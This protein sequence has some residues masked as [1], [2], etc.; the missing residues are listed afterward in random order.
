[1][2][3]KKIV[4][5]LLSL[6]M[7]ASMGMINIYA[8]ETATTGYTDIQ[9]HWAKKSIENLTSLGISNASLTS[10]N[11]FQPEK[12]ITRSETIEL[13]LKANLPNDLLKTALDSVQNSNSFTDT[14]NHKLRNYIELSK[15]FEIVVGYGDGTFKPDG[16]I[17]REEF[18]TIL[19]KSQEVI[20]K[21]AAGNLGSATFSDI[22]KDRWSYENISAA[23]KSGIVAGYPNGTFGPQNDITRAEAY[24]MVNNY[25]NLC[26]ANYKG[27]VGFASSNGKPLEG[28]EVNLKNIKSDKIV[29]TVLSNKYGQYRFDVADKDNFK[30]ETSDGDLFGMIPKVTTP[31]SPSLLASRLTLEKTV[32]IS[33]KAYNSNDLGL[34]EVELLFK[35]DKHEFRTV[36]NSSGE[37]KLKLFSYNTYKVYDSSMGQLGEIYLGNSELTNLTLKPTVFATSSNSSEYTGRN[38]SNYN[39]NNIQTGYTLTIQA[40]TGGRILTGLSGN[41]NPGVNIDLLASPES[42]Y[43]FDKWISSNGGSFA[44]I[45]SASTKFTMPANDTTIVANFT[46]ID[47]GGGE[48]NLPTITVRT[49][50]PDNTR[51]NGIDITYTATASR[52]ASITEISYSINGGAEEYIYLSGGN[53]IT[54]KGTLG[55]GRVL[56]IPGE[57]NIKFFVK[58]SAG[59]TATFDVRNKPKYDF[60]SMPEYDENYMDDL[61]DGSGLRYATNRIVAFAK[62][63]ATVSQIESAISSIGGTIAG[64]VNLLGMYSIQIPVNT[65]SALKG[66]CESLQSSYPELFDEVFLDIVEDVGIEATTQTNDAWWNNDQWG[67]TAINVPD[68]WSNY[69]GHIRNIK[70]GVVDNGFRSTH[71]DLNIPASNVFNRSLGDD[72]HGTHVIGTIGAIHNNNKG[73]AGVI[74]IRRESLY[75]FDSFDSTDRN[76]NI[77]GASSLTAQLEGLA[78]NIAHGTKIVNYSMG[79]GEQASESNPEY[80]MAMEKL[81]N[82]GYD[83]VVVHSAGN[84]TRDASLNGCFSHVTEADLRDHIITVGSTDRNGN[85]ASSSNY[86]NMVD[87]VAPGVGIYS[88]VSTNDSAYDN[89]NGTSMAAPHVTGV[90]A[91]VW[92]ANPGLSG[93]QVKQIIVDSANNYGLEVRDNRTSVPANNRLTYHQVTAKAAV[94]MAIGVTPVLTTGELAGQIIAAMPDG[95][96]GNA[97]VGATISLYSGINNE[98]IRKVNSIA[99]GQYRIDRIDTGRYYLEIAAEGYI[100]ERFFVQIEAGVTTYIH[101]LSAVPESSENGT[102]SGSIINAFNGSI[103]QDEIKLEFRRG[104]DYDQS[105]PGNVVKSIVVS[106]GSYSVSLPAGNYTVTATGTGYIMTK[107]YIYSYGGNSIGNQDVVISPEFATGESSIRFV[108]TWGEVPRD[109]DSHLTGPTP[110]GNRFHIFYANKDFNY[111]LS[112][113][114]SKLYA[115]LDIDD[116]T[117]YGPETVT[118]NAFSDGRYDYYIHD[119]TNRNSTTS[120]YLRNSQAVVRVYNSNNELLR[121]FN[122]PTG[123]SAST[124]WHVFSVD[125]RNG[126][127]TIVPVNTMNNEPTSPINIGNNTSNSMSRILMDQPVHLTEEEI[128]AKKAAELEAGIIEELGTEIITERAEED[129]L[130]EE[131]ETEVFDDIEQAS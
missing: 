45:N 17:T 122:V 61:S 100:P 104:I 8:E 77:G 120:D 109:L 48:E 15:K 81:L 40:G 63:D 91:L 44:D 130:S 23:A 33:G 106:N 129:N 97:I 126:E 121:T 110:E 54:A 75:G 35:S 5:F 1:M 86:G 128:E 6:L 47:N 96:D 99:G 42:G 52:N 80:S 46:L 12:K 111:D 3:F 56:L 2:G 93:A 21:L 94:E 55:T 53:G 57:N 102:V 59:K 85:M 32:Q 71:E 76:G 4:S 34:N 30:I 107:S 36:T 49:A 28:I 50:F 16:L 79:S 112:G 20:E 51:Q 18:A 66:I 72:N 73:L 105:A 13:I 78:W 65:E 119:Y 24:T 127:Y 14:T 84:S 25:Y 68:V 95:S 101:R 89:Y 62:S 131:F 10:S 22:L 58:D 116:V 98:P 39:D 41:Y 117:S 11:Q 9:E 26:F 67:L 29:Q 114:V 87:V 118:I 83:F 108:L 124:I 115:N 31:L 103:V 88:S 27:I 92:A 7:V 70:V 43:K 90:A 125:V 60:G 82:Y 19:V 123:G 69:S 38:D 64:Q 37:F 74:N 113:G